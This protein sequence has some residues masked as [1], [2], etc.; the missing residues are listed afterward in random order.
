MD[1]QP[2]MLFQE[3]IVALHPHRNPTRKSL[4]LCHLIENILD[5]LRIGKEFERLTFRV[6]QFVL[7]FYQI[8]VL[9]VSRLDIFHIIYNPECRI[10]ERLLRHLSAVEVLARLI[11]FDV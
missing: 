8:A 1:G 2:C 5:V 6:G 3:V 4:Q 10:D 9:T 7:S 11:R